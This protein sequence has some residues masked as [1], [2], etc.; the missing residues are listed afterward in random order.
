M[1]RCA[2]GSKSTR[3]TRLPS[4]A[5]AAP[6]LTVVVVFPTPPFWFINAITRMRA[7]PCEMGAYPYVHILRKVRAEARERSLVL[8]HWSFVLCHCLHWPRQARFM[9]ETQRTNDQ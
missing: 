9:Q 6:R 8:R 3:Q 2:W 1:V 7:P 4:S 5:R